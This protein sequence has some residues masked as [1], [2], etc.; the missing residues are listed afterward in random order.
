VGLW[1][2]FLHQVR[3]DPE[4][5]AVHEATYLAYRNRLEALILA[6]PGHGDPARSRALAIACNGVID[7]LWMEGGTLPESF[8]PGEPERIGLAA[9]RAILGLPA[10]S[11]G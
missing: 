6:L 11:Q 2:G 3:R 8:A 1:A 9:V 5:R 10:E 7:G 4:M